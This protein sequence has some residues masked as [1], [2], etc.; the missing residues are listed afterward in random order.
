MTSSPAP[1]K[2]AAGAPGKPAKQVWK[3]RG[4]AWS[5]WL[6]LYLSMLS[7]FVVLFFS[8]TGLTLNHAEWFDR[9]QAESKRTGTLPVAWVNAPDT[10]RIRKLEIVELLRG[11]YAVKGA[12][13]DFLVEDDQCS[14]SFKGPGYSAD[15]FI[16]RATGT[17]KLTELRLGWVAVL[18]DLHKGRDSG[19]GWSWL[20]DI[21]AVFLVVVSLS[22]LAMLFFLK[23][24]RVRG[25]VVGIAGG[26][27]CYLLY[28]LLVP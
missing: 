13:S 15:A 27:I 11:K 14:V 25:V 16:D 19:P 2:P 8:V 24:K 5:R 22:G 6:H 20:I 9:Q 3:K 12:L 7:F 26:A 1:L 18:N 23:N 21:S 4:A 28:Y 10:A 17:F